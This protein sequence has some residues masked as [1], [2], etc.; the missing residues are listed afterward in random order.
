MAFH[1]YDNQQRAIVDAA[2]KIL[3]A[4]YPN[5]VFNEWHFDGLYHIQISLPKSGK[6]VQVFQGARAEDIV[7]DVH[8]RI[9]ELR[10][11]AEDLLA[12]T[13][14]RKSDPEIIDALKLLRAEGRA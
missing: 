13:D 11:Q 2:T 6:C 7:D 3:E 1:D 12:D 14:W 4:A 8:K 9:G 10:K 5:A